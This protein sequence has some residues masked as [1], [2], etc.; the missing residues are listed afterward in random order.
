MCYKF[1][2]KSYFLLTLNSELKTSGK[3][4]VA[5]INF[6]EKRRQ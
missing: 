4:S 3:N 5:N 6:T 2:R 1:S